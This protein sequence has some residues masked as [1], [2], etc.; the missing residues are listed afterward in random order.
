MVN[1]TRSRTRWRRA[2]QHDERRQRFALDFSR[3]IIRLG[4]LRKEF[5]DNT[6]PAF[7]QRG[8]G[9]LLGPTILAGT[10]VRFE[11]TA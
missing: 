1:A 11:M 5:A 7:I 9:R 6:L 8:G 3:I 4:S 10:G 2:R